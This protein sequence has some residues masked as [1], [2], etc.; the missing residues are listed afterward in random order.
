MILTTGTSATDVVTIFVQTAVDRKLW[1]SGLFKRWVEVKR[2]TNQKWWNWRKRVRLRSEKLE[3][4]Y[5]PTD[6]GLTKNSLAEE[7]MT[8]GLCKY[9][10]R[11]GSLWGCRFNMKNNRGTANSCSWK[12]R[13]QQ[14]RI[15][16]KE[17]Q[18]I[19]PGC[20]S[21]GRKEWIEVVNGLRRAA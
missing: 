19:E 21:T 2:L 15:V 10:E 9:W 18:W 17:R 7:R 12:V 16:R 1:C 14:S 13:V 8:I 3:R 6:G 5:T 20:V 11:I 4:D